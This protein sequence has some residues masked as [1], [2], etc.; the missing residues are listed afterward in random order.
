MLLG[1]Y[2][3]TKY[4]P[5]LAKLIDDPEVAIHSIEA[6]TKLKDLSQFEKIKKLSE[7]TKSTP[8]KSYARRYI[9]KLSNNK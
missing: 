5:I 9:K 7:C 6:L 4:L 1:K 3:S 2:G 8:I